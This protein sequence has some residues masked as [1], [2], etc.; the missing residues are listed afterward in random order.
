MTAKASVWVTRHFEMASTLEDFQRLL[1]AVAAVE[2][3]P[4]LNQFTHVEHGKSWSLRLSNPRK[5]HVAGLTLPLLDV[6]LTFAGYTEAEMDAVVERFFTY[7][8][9]GGG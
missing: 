2:F 3:D 7:F 9:R 4:A 5:R 6:A 1:P 8:R